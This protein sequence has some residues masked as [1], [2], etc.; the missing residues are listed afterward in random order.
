MT[1]TRYTVNFGGYDWLEETD[2]PGVCISGFADVWPAKWKPLWYQQGGANRR[3]DKA[4]SRYCKLFPHV[5]FDLVGEVTLYHD[6]N[7]RLK[8]PPE[9]FIDFLGDSDIAAFIH[10]QRDCIYDEA[11]ICAECGAADPEKIAV[12]AFT[13]R[14]DGYPEHNGLHASSVLVRRD[15]PQIRALSALWWEQ[16][17]KHTYRDQLSHDYCLWKLGIKCAT[18]PGNLGR[19][20]LMERGPHARIPKPFWEDPS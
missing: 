8:V 12:Q 11:L 19:N 15:T 7:V 2:Y 18:I 17:Q 5:W 16:L 13:Y 14:Q 3:T 4:N 20:D 10:P 1:F 9:T 6:A